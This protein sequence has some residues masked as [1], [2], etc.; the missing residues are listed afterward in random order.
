MFL[1]FNLRKQRQMESLLSQ[2]AEEFNPDRMSSITALEKEV[3]HSFSRAIRKF[4][5]ISG[6]FRI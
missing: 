3:R 5:L 4:V 1:V 2:F 6:R